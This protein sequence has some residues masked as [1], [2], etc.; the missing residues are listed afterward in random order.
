MV[1]VVS[2]MVANKRLLNLILVKIDTKKKIIR[3]REK[4]FESLSL[5]VWLSGHPEEDWHR[6]IAGRVKT[7][8]LSVTTII[9]IKKKRKPKMENL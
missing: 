9:K 6:E 3:N 2:R 4:I 8:S 1:A 5:S 7:A